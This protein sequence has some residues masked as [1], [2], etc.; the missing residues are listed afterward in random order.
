[1]KEFVVILG[2]VA[3]L[4]ALTAVRYRKQIAGMLQV[5]RML[6]S[7]RHQ[8]KDVAGEREAE[9]SSKLVSCAKCGTWTPESSA[10]RMGPSAYYCSKKCIGQI[11]EAG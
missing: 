8:M 7:A 4:L 3:I 6:R 11:V 10:I 2:A 9:V 1:M 5:Y